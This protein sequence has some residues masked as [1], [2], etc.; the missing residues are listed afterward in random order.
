VST[1]GLSASGGG[2]E[3]AAKTEFTVRDCFCAFE[4]RF[5]NVDALRPVL[6]LLASHGYIQK[7]AREQLRGRPSVA[8]DV[9]PAFL[10][11]LLEAA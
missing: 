5:G 10:R 4:S 1:A 11:S 3:R 2:E 8:D 6:A 7:R 9:N